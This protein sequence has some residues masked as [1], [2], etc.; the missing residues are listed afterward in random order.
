[1]R[2]EICMIRNV[3]RLFAIFRGFR[4]VAVAFNA[5]DAMACRR[6]HN[7]AH[8]KQNRRKGYAT[9]DGTTNR[10]AKHSSKN[11]S[12]GEKEYKDECL[13]RLN[14]S[15]KTVAASFDA[16]F[17]GVAVAKAHLITKKNIFV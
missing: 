7:H 16:V 13:H 8:A 5:L 10:A 9:F 6:V 11:G 14:I 4:V 3:R 1:M 2:V 12:Y 15:V 17:S